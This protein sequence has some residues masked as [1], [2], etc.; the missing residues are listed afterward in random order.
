MK[1]HLVSNLALL[2]ERAVDECF[3]NEK[4]CASGQDGTRVLTEWRDS[5]KRPG[6]KVM[7]IEIMQDDESKFSYDDYGTECRSV[8]G[9]RDMVKEPEEDK[10]DIER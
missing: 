7:H 8:S 3:F 6:Y 10:D 9:N 4:G 1:S 2:I 5:E